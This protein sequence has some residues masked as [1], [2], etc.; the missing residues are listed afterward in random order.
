MLVS[1]VRRSKSFDK[2]RIGEAIWIDMTEGMT[3]AAAKLSL[4][5]E[6]SK[7]ESACRIHASTR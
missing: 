6:E 3:S 7:I 2:L 1:I 4:G 5:V